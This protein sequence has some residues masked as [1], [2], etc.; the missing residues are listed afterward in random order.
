MVLYVFMEGFS[1]VLVL[2]FR[3]ILLG[4]LQNFKFGNIY[5]LLTK[6]RYMQLEDVISISRSF[7]G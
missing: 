2:M 3:L 5:P 1:F 7:M 4:L 6:N